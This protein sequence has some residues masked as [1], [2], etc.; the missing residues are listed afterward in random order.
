MESDLDKET[1]MNFGIKAVIGIFVLGMV[2]AQFESLQ[3]KLGDIY[4]KQQKHAERIREL[5][6][7]QAR[8]E[9]I[10]RRLDRIERK[11]DEFGGTLREFASEKK[12]AD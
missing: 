11:Q 7:D 6:A 1:W 10:L 9:D 8:W 12:D 3:N 4:Q 5:E 2:Y